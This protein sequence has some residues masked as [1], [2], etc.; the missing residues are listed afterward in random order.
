MKIPA[1]FVIGPKDAEEG[2]VSIRLKD[3]EVKVKLSEL[4]EYLKTIK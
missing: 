1:V 2:I 4:S 3:S